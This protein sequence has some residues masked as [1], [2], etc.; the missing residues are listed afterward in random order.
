MSAWR[1]AARFVLCSPRAS[2]PRTQRETITVF[3]AARMTSG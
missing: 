2:I 1:S 3:A